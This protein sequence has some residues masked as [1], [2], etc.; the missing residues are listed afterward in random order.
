L[1]KNRSSPSVSK[2][3]GSAANFQLLSRQVPYG[4]VGIYGAVADGMRLIDRKTR[5]L[6]PD[7]GERL[8]EGFLEE[9]GVPKALIK[10]VRSE[11]SI[12]V[13]ELAQWG[14]RSH[15]AGQPVAC[16]RKSL[17]DALHRDPV[18]SRMA[19]AL[20]DH[21]FQNQDDTELKRLKRRFDP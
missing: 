6:T 4:V 12:A 5:A 16:E 15:L 8:G 9:T 17:A 3:A 11:T 2:A 20:A 21:P 1:A 13:A 19:E 10:A 18:R 14:R 7:L